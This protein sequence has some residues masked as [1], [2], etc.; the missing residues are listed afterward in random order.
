ALPDTPDAPPLGAAPE[1]PPKPVPETPPVAAP[2]TPPAPPLGAAPL[3][4]TPPVAAP[5][6]G[7][8]SSFESPPPPSLGEHAR[9]NAVTMLA[10]RTEERSFK[11]SQR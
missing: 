8:P 7:V 2:P 5:P 11:A 9:T 1:L 6:E 4:L 10:L 3:P